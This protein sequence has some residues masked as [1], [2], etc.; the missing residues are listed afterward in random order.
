MCSFVNWISIRI[1]S[2]LNGDQISS[3]NGVNQMTKALF[4]HEKLDVYQVTLSYIENAFRC[5]FHLPKQFRHTRDQWIRASQSIALN[6]AEG[7]GKRSQRERERFFDIARGSALECCAIQDVLV[8]SGGL[9]NSS[10]EE[11]KT[12][13]KRVVSMLSKMIEYRHKSE[14]K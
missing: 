9:Q 1:I 8:V 5:S 6:I 3:A 11:L 2:V 14:D 4:D 12:Q 10:D 13:L 7:N